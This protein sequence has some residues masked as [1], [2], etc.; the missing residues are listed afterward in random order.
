MVCEWFDLNISNDC[1]LPS[2]SGECEA[3][4]PAYAFNLSSC[5]EFSW[6]G[7]GGIAPFW[8]LEDCEAACGDD[9]I[10][11][12][13][14]EFER[15]LLIEFDVLGRELVSDSQILIRVYDDG[16]VEKKMFLKN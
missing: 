11:I 12:L 5:Y 14:T 15:K 7:C 9:T 16:T 3:A 13:E 8:T 4:I 2:E 1:E 10:N 6:G